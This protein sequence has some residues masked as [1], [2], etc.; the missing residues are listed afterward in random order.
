ME[1]PYNGRA[2]IQDNIT[3][4]QIMI[5]VKRNGFILLFT[6]VWL[7]GWLFGEIFALGMVTGLFG[8]RGPANLFI[9][10]WLI[11]WTVGGFFAFRMFLWN[12]RG[13][14]IIT[15]GQ[16]RLTIDKKGVLLFKPKTYDLNEVKNIRVQDDNLGVAGPFGVRPGGFGAFNAGGIIRFDYGLQ[17][18]KFAGGIDE[19]EAKFILEKLKERHLLTDKNYH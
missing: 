13:R 14:E 9:A 6:G 5:P 16:G 18:V 11:A 15:I 8:G 10:F 12:L 1:K 17:T 2:T 19:A 7:I 3:D 4:L